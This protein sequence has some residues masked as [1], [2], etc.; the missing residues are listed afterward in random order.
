MS[1]QGGKC[2]TYL[3]N[4]FIKHVLSSKPRAKHSDINCKYSLLPS[5]ETIQGMASP[6]SLGRQMERERVPVNSTAGESLERKQKYGVP[7]ADEGTPS[8]LASSK[9]WHRN[10]KEGDRCFY[11]SQQGEKW[12]RQFGLVL[13]RWKIGV[14]TGLLWP[15]A[16]QITEPYFSCR[17][18]PVRC[19]YQP[20]NS[21]PSPDSL[22]AHPAS[23]KTHSGPRAF[24]LALRSLVPSIKFPKLCPAQ[25]SLTCQLSAE[26]PFPRVL[27]HNIVI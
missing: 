4:K 3:T 10:A 23:Y 16:G 8:I 18:P 15:H 1:S 21:K 26:Q 12:E 27:T 25:A 9:W 13:G 11:R 24:A 2:L 19:L 17:C 14:Q 7:S 20:P 5:K 22:P 6:K